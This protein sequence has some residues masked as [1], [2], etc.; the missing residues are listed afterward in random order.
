L[1]KAASAP[2]AAENERVSAECVRRG[3]PVQSVC[4][5]RCMRVQALSRYIHTAYP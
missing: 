4:S 1:G 5:A 2:L 3:Q